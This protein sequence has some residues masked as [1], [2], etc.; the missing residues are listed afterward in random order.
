MFGLAFPGHIYLAVVVVVVVAVGQSLACHH[1]K[2]LTQSG[3]QTNIL[4]WT[5]QAGNAMWVFAMVLL[6]EIHAEWSIGVWD[7]PVRSEK[8]HS[9]RNY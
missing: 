8:S 7:A 2:K 9:C 5:W 6:D 1:R 4:T 3:E